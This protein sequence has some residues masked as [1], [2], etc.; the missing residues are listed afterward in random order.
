MPRIGVMPCILR[1]IRFVNLN[2]SIEFFISIIHFKVTIEM[3]AGPLV[4]LIE[5][6]RPCSPLWALFAF[7]KFDSI[8]RL[9]RLISSRGRWTFR[10]PGLPQLRP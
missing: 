7:V 10:D 1:S 6:S 3:L 2:R 5:V 9:I 8:F 4:K